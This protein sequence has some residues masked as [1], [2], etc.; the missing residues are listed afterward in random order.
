[1][2]PTQ[3]K[4]QRTP[5]GL[6]AMHAISALAPSLQWAA[7]L[8]TRRPRSAASPPNAEDS[9]VQPRLWHQRAP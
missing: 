4:R 3:P 2:R 1:M 9:H 5:T 6:T 7:Q 8:T